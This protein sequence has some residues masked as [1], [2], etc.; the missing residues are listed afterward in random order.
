MRCTA[1]RNA[2]KGRPE[3][4]LGGVS[5]RRAKG[6]QALALKD[7]LRFVREQNCVA[8]KGEAKQ[9][10]PLRLGQAG[11]SQQ[12]H[13]RPEHAARPRRRWTGEVAAEGLHVAI[14]AP[15]HKSCPLDG[16]SVMLI[17]LKPEPVSAAFRDRRITQ[18]DQEGVQPGE[19][20]HER[21]GYARF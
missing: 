19:L 12:P 5:F 20:L 7:L 18:C 16:E 17:E 2:L 10:A 15:R 8:I 14:G 13:R 11:A 1:A 4:S 21:E 6:L 3:R 9:V